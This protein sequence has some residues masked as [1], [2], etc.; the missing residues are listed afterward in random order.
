MGIKEKMMESMMGNMSKEEKMDMMNKMMDSFFSNMSDEEKKEMMN[1]MMQNMMGDNKSTPMGGMMGMMMGGKSGM[2]DM[3]SKMMGGKKSE[4]GTAEMPWNMCRKMMANMTKSTDLAVFSTPEIRQ[5]F[6]EW[7]EQIE[8]EIL[9]FTK[10]SETIE[11]DKI[12]KHFKLTKE[13]IIY[14]LNRLAQKEKIK[15]KSENK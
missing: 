7:T 8:T 9:D 6:E 15:F 5:L 13:S 1:N 2:M 4:D 14:F 10:Q 12:Q 11:V 3:M